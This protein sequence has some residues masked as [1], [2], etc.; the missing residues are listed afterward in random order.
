MN[1]NG[2]SCDATGCFCLYRRDIN[3][4]K[5]QLNIGRAQDNPG[6]H[7]PV[8]I[9]VQELQTTGD[10][11]A[12]LLYGR[13]GEEPAEPE[14]DSQADDADFDVSAA[15]D[16]NSNP[17]VDKLLVQGML[18]D[19]RQLMAMVEA[20]N[21]NKDAL[22]DAR[23]HL[24]AVKARLQVSSIG[25]STKSRKRTANVKP[26]EQFRFRRTKTGCRLPMQSTIGRPSASRV[27]AVKHV[28]PSTKKRVGIADC[29]VSGVPDCDQQDVERHDVGL[30][31]DGSG[32]GDV[33][34]CVANEEVVQRCDYATMATCTDHD[35]DC[36]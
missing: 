27:T 10:A 7:P 3:N 36:R 11:S 15:A 31:F 4:V 26:N 22:L 29:I 23:K 34:Y 14:Q 24:S 25:I 19:C 6:D 28:L 13:Q 17:T 16:D 30:L 2:A 33:P 18:S 9:W 20:G 8:E 5:V 35:Y 12:V 32:C 1:N 21:Y